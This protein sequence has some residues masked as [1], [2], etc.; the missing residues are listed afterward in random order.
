MVD[1]DVGAA[2]PRERLLWPSNASRWSDARES[3]SVD[4]RDAIELCRAAK[5]CPRVSA[6]HIVRRCARTIEQPKLDEMAQIRGPTLLWDATGSPDSAPSRSHAAKT[7][8][9]TL[10]A[11]TFRR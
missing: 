8:N 11:S 1:D 9:G 2:L 5:A 4:R 3:F 6:R 7:R 10:R